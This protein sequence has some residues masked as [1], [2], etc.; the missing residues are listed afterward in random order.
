[1]IANRGVGIWAVGGSQLAA[2]RDVIASRPAL[3]GRLVRMSCKLQTEALAAIT[4][5]LDIAPP[6]HVGE[7][8]MH[9]TR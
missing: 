4:P 1:M 6:A 3:G 9:C 8:P 7:I 5:T 2:A